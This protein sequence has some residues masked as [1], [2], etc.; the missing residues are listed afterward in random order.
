MAGCP[1]TWVR[2]VL[3]ITAKPAKDGDPA[4]HLMV[5]VVRDGDERVKVW[6]PAQGA[7][8]LMDLIPDDVMDKIRNEEIPI[9]DIMEDLRREPTLYPRPIF[10]SH[11]DARQ[12]D[13]WLE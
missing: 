6:L 7:R 1:Y 11:D 3:G 10:S 4:K 13:V 9:D 8:R 5:R 2:G 12:V